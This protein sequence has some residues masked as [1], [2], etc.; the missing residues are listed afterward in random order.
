MQV[1]KVILIAAGVAL[2]GLGSLSAEESV[3]LTN[4]SGKTV[5]VYLK[6]ATTDTVT[7]M[8][9]KG[10]KV[11]T[12]P[13]AKLSTNSQKKIADWKKA[14]GGLSAEF[15]IDFDSGRSRKKVSYDDEK[16]TIKPSVSIINRDSGTESKRLKVTTIV[17]GRAAW[18]NSIYQ[19]FIKDERDLPSIDP[20]ESF[21]FDL[22]AFKTD[23]DDYGYKHGAKYFGY[24]VIIH[25]EKH[26]V[27]AHKIKPSTYDE[28]VLAQ[29]KKLRASR[30]YD[31]N[32]QGVKV[33][34]TGGY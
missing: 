29:Y 22:K 31:R 4:S 21:E 24:A 16:H 25:D 3:S 19:V 10:R 15:E 8:T 13:L 23:Y 1:L 12:F 17:L 28:A 5:E 30:Y 9:V 11:H 14:G 7:V 32:M 27:Y 18:D 33:S 6:S 2:C 26:Q 34:S 20:R